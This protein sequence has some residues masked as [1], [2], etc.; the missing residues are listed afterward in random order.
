LGEERNG[1][2]SSAG[3]LGSSRLMEP[4]AAAAQDASFNGEISREF[5]SKD[6]SGPSEVSARVYCEGCVVQKGMYWPKNAR[7][8]GPSS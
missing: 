7:T 4:I 5:S 2:V 8:G 6:S 3:D 1:A